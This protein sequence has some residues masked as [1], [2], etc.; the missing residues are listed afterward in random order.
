MTQ[1]NPEIWIEQIV[2]AIEFA[3]GIGIKN[4]GSNGN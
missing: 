3:H 4:G 2:R 1:D